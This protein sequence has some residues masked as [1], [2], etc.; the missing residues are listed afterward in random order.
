MP[1]EILGLD[2]VPHPG[3]ELRV[4]ADLSSAKELVAHR[5]EKRRAAELTGSSKVSL[6]E[7]FARA[8]SGEQ[9]ELRVILKADVQGSVEALKDA[10]TG[11]STQKVKV[12]VIST[13]V[14][15][16]VE[17]DIEFAVASEAI[18]IGF[19]VRPDTKALK[20][21]RASGV[22]VR[23][24]SVIYEA[25]DEV[26]LAMRGLLS[27]V[28]K[29]K[30][31]GRAEVRQTFNV[32]KVGTV[33][34]CAVVDGIITRNANIRL[35]RDSRPIYDGKLASLKRFKDDVREVREGFECGMNIERFNDVKEGDIIEAYEIVMQEAPLDEPTSDEA[36]A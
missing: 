13:G 2:G 32:P 26:K 6:Q 31:L 33:A 16:V 30:Y 15:A 5:R 19:G 7:L 24:Y 22:D 23:T 28:E 17:S 25:V 27:P 3:D 36:R 21:A 11:L 8:Q 29:E 35:L 10:L 4:A 12:S 14:G 18:V 1:V 34:G 20:A 9:K